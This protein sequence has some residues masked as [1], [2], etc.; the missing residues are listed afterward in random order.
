[1]P[2]HCPV[3]FDHWWSNLVITIT[4]QLITRVICGSTSLN[5]GSIYF[6]VVAKWQ[7]LHHAVRLC[8]TEHY[9]YANLHACLFFSL[10]WS[11]D[12]AVRSQVFFLRQVN[13]HRH[14]VVIC[15]QCRWQVSWFYIRSQYLQ[16]HTPIT[17]DYTKR[18]SEGFC[19]NKAV[20]GEVDRKGC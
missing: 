12:Q 5:F 11:F 10:P 16:L 3:R 4:Y 17:V 9:K 19:K 13:I 6:V 14:T 15:Q 1:M 2:H 20:F 18:F 7:L 8:E